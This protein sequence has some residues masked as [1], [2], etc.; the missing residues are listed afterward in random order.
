MVMPRPARNIVILVCLPLFVLTSPVDRAA[1][2]SYRTRTSIMISE[3]YCPLNDER[4]LALL[5]SF[6]RSAA[7][8]RILPSSK[9]N[10]LEKKTGYFKTRIEYKGTGNGIVK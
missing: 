5:H 10:S 4:R 8:R 2:R 9:G 7:L 6:L 1:F 3:L